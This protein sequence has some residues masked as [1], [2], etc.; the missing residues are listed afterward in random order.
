IDECSEI[1]DDCQWYMS[2]YTRRVPLSMS[3]WL[4]ARPGQQVMRRC[5]RMSDE[6]RWMP[7]ELRQHTWFVQMSLYVTP[8][9]LGCRRE[10]LH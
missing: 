3:S 8:F 7:G 10:E 2:Q 1:K 5:R 9:F 4:Q 6:Q